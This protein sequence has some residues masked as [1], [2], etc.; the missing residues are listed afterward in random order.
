[1]ASFK[2]KLAIKFQYLDL[3]FL[4]RLRTSSE[5]VKESLTVLNTFSKANDVSKGDKK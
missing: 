2:G 5:D 3:S 1:M 4:A